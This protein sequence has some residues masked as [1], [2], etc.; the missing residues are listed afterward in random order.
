MTEKSIEA[1]LQEPFEPNDIKWRVRQS[2]LKNGRA[3]MIVLPYITGRAIQNRLDDVFGVGGWEVLQEETKNGDGFICTLSMLVNDRWVRKQDVAQKTDIEAL[4]GGA[5]GALKRAGALAGIGRYL[6]QLKE[7]FADC[8]PCEYRSQAVNNFDT[9]YEDKKK[10]RAQGNWMCVDWTP[11]QLP[12]WALP[13]LD[14]S[15]FSKAIADAKNIM[16]I[17]IAY[18]DAYRWASS[19]SRQDL[20]D[21]FKDEKKAAVNKLDNEAKDNIAERFNVVSKWLEGEIRGINLVPDSG[22]VHLVGE[23]IREQLAVKC[24]GQYFNKESLYTNLKQAVSNRV[25]AIEGK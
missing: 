15:K 20:V 8:V 23:R 1:R 14:S 2:G 24:Q 18:N 7:G 13:G 25:N 10:G 16:D 6:Y 12:E 17:D 9:V 19:F 22:T 5:S 4:K 21:M 11:P 3:W